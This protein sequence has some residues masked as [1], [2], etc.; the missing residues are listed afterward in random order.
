MK[1]TLKKPKNFYK[2][3]STNYSFN[4]LIED[5][6][7]LAELPTAPTSTQ[8]ILHPKDYEFFTKNPYI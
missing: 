5:I 1:H 6:M 2:D 8:I 3:Y 7:Y 4:K